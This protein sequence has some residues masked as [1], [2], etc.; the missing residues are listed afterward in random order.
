MLTKGAPT[1]APFVMV[2]AGRDTR[3]IYYIASYYY[4]S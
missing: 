2:S 4:R 3:L 1:G